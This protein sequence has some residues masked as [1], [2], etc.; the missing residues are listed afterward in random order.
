MP[1]TQPNDGQD[2]GGDDQSSGSDDQAH[3]SAFGVFGHGAVEGERPDREGDGVGKND[4]QSSAQKV[5]VRPR[6]G[7]EEGCAPARARELSRL[8]SRG[9]AGSPRPA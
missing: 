4:A 2:D 9:C 8:Q 7:T 3:V 6:P 5:M 1:L